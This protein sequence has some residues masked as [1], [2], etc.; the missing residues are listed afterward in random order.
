[1]VI[2]TKK[3]QF[4]QN[5]QHM[6]SYEIN[7]NIDIYFILNICDTQSLLIPCSAFKETR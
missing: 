3:C 7:S 5:K 2:H 4:V 6:K 1:M